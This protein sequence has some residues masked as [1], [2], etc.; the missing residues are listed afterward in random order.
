M[1]LLKLQNVSVQYGGLVALNNLSFEA[2][3]NEVLGI[4]GPNGAGKTTMFNA[5]TGFVH[6]NKARIEFE[7][8]NITKLKPHEI[9]RI[10][11]AR[12]FQLVKIFQK[13][14]VEENVIIGALIQ[15]NDTKKAKTIAEQE[16]SFFKLSNRKN[17]LVEDLAAAEQKKVELAR[18]LA[19]KPK[20]LLLDEF[21]AGLNPTE[22][23]EM[24][25]SLEQI[26][27]K[28]RTILMV[29]HVMKAVMA[30]SDRI[31]VI[32][33]GEK[34]AQG[35]PEQIANDKQVIR[36]YLGDE[37]HPVGTA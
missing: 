22:T 15:T 3:N 9:C 6:P 8:T 34:I 29:E 25:L 27:N 37:N 18:A 23:R 5:I 20:L 17:R 35:K 2:E 32:D 12:T 31:V 26:R 19:T 21:F 10:G 30:I 16:I 13:L 11:I 14:T 33:H 4:I 24:A 7:E 36:A 28:T 1:T